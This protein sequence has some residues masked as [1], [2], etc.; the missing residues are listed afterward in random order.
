M[1]PTEQNPEDFSSEPLRV[2]ELRGAPPRER[3]ILFSAP[4]VL[5]ILAGTKS[6]TR[7]TCKAR[8]R[9][10]LFA[11]EDDGSPQWADSFITDPGNRD[12]LLSEAIA[13]PGDILWVRETFLLTEQG[14]PI[15]RANWREDAK[16]RGFDSIPA[17]ETSLRWTS[18]IHMPRAVSRIQLE[19]LTVRVERLQE[20]TEAGAMAEGVGSV[21]EYAALWNTINGSGAWA[22]NPLVWV[23]EFRRRSK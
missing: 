5:A 6:E 18:A 11:V 3:P 16:A 8:R 1:V 21:E 9:V 12:W 7:R 13:R 17:D 20:I 2:S 22:L 23:Y 4:M 10:S 14:Q 19:L 15:Y